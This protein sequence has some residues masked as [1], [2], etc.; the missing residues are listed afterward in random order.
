MLE[1]Y[2]DSYAACI[3]LAGA[4]RRPVTLRPPD[5]ALDVDALDAAAGPRTRVLLLNTPHNPTG[6]VLTRGELEAIARVCVEHDLVCVSDEV[7][8]H[9]VYDG[10]HVPIATLPGMAQRTLTVS[11]VGKTFS[12][13]RRPR[14]IEG[15]HP[16][17]NL[18]VRNVE[19]PSGSGSSGPVSRP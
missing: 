11:S 18:S 13:H 12:V 3:T 19:T 6:R 17:R 1:P 15:T 10:E 4:H 14:D 16:G 9:L 2:Y 5:F 8:E 7:Y